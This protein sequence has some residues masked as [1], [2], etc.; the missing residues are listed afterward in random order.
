MNLASRVLGQSVRRLSGDI[1]ERST[2]IRRLLAESFIDPSP[3]HRRVLPGGELA[4][5][6]AHDPRVLRA[7]PGCR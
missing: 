7:T 6:G 3:L 2:D 1:R 5:A 4:G